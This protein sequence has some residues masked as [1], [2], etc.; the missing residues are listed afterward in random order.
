MKKKAATRKS[1]TSRVMRISGENYAAFTQLK[2]RFARKHKLKKATYD[3]FMVELLK[4][5][6]MLLD[7]TELYVVENRVFEDIAEARGEAILS[8]VRKGEPPVM[9]LICIV[10]GRDQGRTA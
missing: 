3:E 10:V 9:P 1:E 4:V 5:A 2:E 7:G 6:R 8:A